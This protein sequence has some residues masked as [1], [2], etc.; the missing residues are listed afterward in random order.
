MVSC[1][2]NET[3]S[4]TYLRDEAVNLPKLK[5]KAR[6]IEE[7]PQ[8][9]AIVVWTVRFRVIAWRERSHLVSVSRV[10]EEEELDLVGDLCGAHGASALARSNDN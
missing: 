8:I 2:R 6:R 3:S 7:G 1:V 10:L 9:E 4:S 5:G